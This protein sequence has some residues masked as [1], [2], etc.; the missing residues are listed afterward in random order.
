MTS[1]IQTPMMKINLA[2]EFSEIPG[3]RQKN[4]GPNSGEEFLERILQPAY[5]AAVAEGVQLFIDLDGTEGY[6]TSFLE[7]AF[8]SLAR[9]YG[10]D[11]VLKRLEFKSDEEPY[12]IDEIKI[13][14]SEASAK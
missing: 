13:Y 7:S 2:K 9:I 5:D 1:T 12:L 10:P 6:A 11:A 4:E 14:I 8:G 3:P